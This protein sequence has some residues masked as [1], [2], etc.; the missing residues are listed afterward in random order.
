MLVCYRKPE[1]GMA[2]DLH[3]FFDS[4]ADR[5]ANIDIVYGI[6]AGI[7]VMF[8]KISMKHGAGI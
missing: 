5:N 4:S 7:V 2:S 1:D 8:E 6:A 3:L